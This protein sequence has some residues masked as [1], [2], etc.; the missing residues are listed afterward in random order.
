MKDNNT[1][2]A[3]DKI[4]EALIKYGCSEEESID[5]ICSVIQDQRDMDDFA[6]N[7]HK[8]IEEDLKNRIC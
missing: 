6:D 5:L 2:D 4:L 3:Y 7:V 1:L 8:I